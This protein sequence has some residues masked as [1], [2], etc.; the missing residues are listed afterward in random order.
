MKFYAIVLN[1]ILL[2]PGIVVARKTED[3]KSLWKAYTNRAEI[4]ME[5]FVL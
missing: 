5:T 2:L 4:C 3:L 1:Y